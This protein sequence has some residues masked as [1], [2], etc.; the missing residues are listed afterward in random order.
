MAEE[1]EQVIW[2]DEDGNVTDAEHA[3]GGEILQRQPDGSVIS[4]TFT[5]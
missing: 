3:V 4:T 5:C 2:V 1:T